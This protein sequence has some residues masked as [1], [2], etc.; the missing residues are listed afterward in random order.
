[1]DLQ[2]NDN[3]LFGVH[4][5]VYYG[6]N[7]R[8][9]E[10]NTRMNTR[11][12][13]DSPLE[14]NFNPRSIPTKHS[15]FPIVN[16]RAPF[17]EPV[18]PYLDYDL[19]A[20]F[21]PGTHRAPPSGYI[22]NVDVET[23]LRNQTMAYQRGCDQCVYVPSSKSELYNSYM[24][25][26]TTRQEDQPHPDLFNT[27]H[28]DQSLHPNIQDTNIGKDRFFNHTRTQLRGSEN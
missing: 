21:N 19:M 5:G 15:L 24:A 7:E 16:R 23:V 14:P 13:S 10:L 4:Q 8:V 9:D 3:R 12:F 28:L 1:M 27:P 17:K 6:Q 20:N 25:S 26:C 22:N 11:Q 18:I 2:I